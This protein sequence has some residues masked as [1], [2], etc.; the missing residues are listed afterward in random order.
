M[1][2]YRELQDRYGKGGV[3]TELLSVFPDDSYVAQH[4]IDTHGLHGLPFLANVDFAKLRLAG[5]PTLLWVDSHGA[6]S[7]SW[8]EELSKEEQDEVLRAIQ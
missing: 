5:T 8:V 2:L 1:E 4:D 6:I 3:R 7:R